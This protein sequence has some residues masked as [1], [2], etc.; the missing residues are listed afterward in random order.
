MNTQRWRC[1][2]TSV[3]LSIYT[4]EDIDVIDRWSVYVYI[5]IDSIFRRADLLI[6]TEA[7]PS[8]DGSTIIAPIIISKDRWF[9]RRPVTQRSSLD[10]FDKKTLFYPYFSRFSYERK[11][12]R[13]GRISQSI[14][15]RVTSASL[16]QERDFFS[17]SWNYPFL[18][19]G[20]HLECSCTRETKHE[21]DDD[22]LLSWMRRL[23]RQPGSTRLNPAKASLPR[24]VSC[25]IPDYHPLN[26]K[27]ARREEKKKVAHERETP[28][29]AEGFPSDSP[30]VEGWL[31]LAGGLSGSVGVLVLLLLSGGKS[32]A[33]SLMRTVTRAEGDSPLE[34]RVPCQ[35][36]VSEG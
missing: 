3:Y 23:K 14:S 15:L 2:W 16:C 9:D 13:E 5:C 10:S 33:L 31:G 26:E 21:D 35:P 36:K 27:Y 11:K 8:M 20:K 17:S 32:G 34:L 30:G 25:S 12:R 18:T 19:R 29:A 7:F 22:F 6:R 4:Q 24:T 28:R 1:Q